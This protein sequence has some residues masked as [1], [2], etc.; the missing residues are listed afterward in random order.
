MAPKKGLKVLGCARRNALS[1][2][3][4]RLNAISAVLICT[5]VRKKVRNKATVKNRQISDREG[6]E[7]MISNETLPVFSVPTVNQ[8]PDLGREETIA[9]H[10]NNTNDRKKL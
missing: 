6:E 1:C 10:Q 2:I 5:R 9:D 3:T 4:G 8:V 7:R